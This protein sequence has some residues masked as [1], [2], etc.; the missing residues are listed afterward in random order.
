MAFNRAQAGLQTQSSPSTM[1]RTSPETEKVPSDKQEWLTPAQRPQLATRPR[2]PPGGWRRPR[3]AS[4]MVGAAALAVFATLWRVGVLTT[5]AA[6]I[7]RAT[8]K[9]AA[10]IGSALVFI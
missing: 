5:L 1:I 6:G 9:A 10:A 7:Y 2:Q 8:V 3:K 4:V